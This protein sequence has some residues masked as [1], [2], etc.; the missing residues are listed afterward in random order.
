MDDWFVSGSVY[1]MGGQRVKYARVAD[2]QDCFVSCASMRL[3]V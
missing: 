2:R 1:G 3:D